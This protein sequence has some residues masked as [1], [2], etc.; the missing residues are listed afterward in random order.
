MSGTRL[1][2]LSVLAGGLA[3]AFALA[4]VIFWATMLASPP[5]SEA[6]IAPIDILGLTLTAHPEAGERPDAF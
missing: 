2:T 4:G 6:R 5:K 3:A 1:G